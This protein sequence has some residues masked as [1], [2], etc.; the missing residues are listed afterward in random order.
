MN[1][2]RAVGSLV[3]FLLICCSVLL[4]ANNPSQQDYERYASESLAS[5]LKERVCPQAPL[6]FNGALRSYC[7]TLV[8]TGRPHINTLINRTTTRQNFVLFSLYE[9][10]LALPSPLRGYQF[11]ILGV[12]REFF[13]Y[14]AR[15]L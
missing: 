14:E 8:D 5:Y 10:Q 6:A 12:M 1:P 13:I 2:L 11:Q 9:T 3:G 4:A 15:E 7:K